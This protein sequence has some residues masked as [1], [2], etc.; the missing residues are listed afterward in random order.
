MLA[1]IN[2]DQTLSTEFKDSITYFTV[3]HLTR[4]RPQIAVKHLF[5][6]AQSKKRDL[7]TL[8]F[9][10]QVISMISIGKFIKARKMI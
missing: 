8:S 6:S 9:E 7:K 3:A 1:Y 10:L 2:A 4:E 5:E